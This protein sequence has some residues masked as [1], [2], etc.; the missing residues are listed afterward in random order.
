MKQN[1]S[2]LMDGE[3]CD[4]DADNLL[5][6]IRKDPA[7]RQEWENYHLIG[8]VL[9]Q[10]DYPCRKMN[11]TFFDRLQAEPTI[12]FPRRQ[13]HIKSSI[14]A[15]SAVA[16]GMAVVLLAWLE[17]GIDSDAQYS[18]QRQQAV[19][20]QTPVQH[21]NSGVNDYLMAHH[22][23]SPSNDV[24]GASTYTRVVASKQILAEK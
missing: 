18:V 4:E 5:G 24:R 17:M 6:K 10:S 11:A 22:E 19:S 16:S 21:W 13:H 15:V 7:A 3:L 8:D 20:V 23:F 14:F 12:F 9:R 2:A 1:I